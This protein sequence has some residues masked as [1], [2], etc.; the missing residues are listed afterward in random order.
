MNPDA[1]PT[2]G[3]THN[4]RAIELVVIRETEAG[5]TSSA[6]INNVPITR[7]VTK[8]VNDNITIKSAS[9]HCT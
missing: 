6:E 9:T 1:A 3:E 5:M 4:M 2:A 7:I 8:I